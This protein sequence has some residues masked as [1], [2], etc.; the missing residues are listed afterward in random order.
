MLLHE[1][2]APYRLILASSSPRR[3]QLMAD[4]G[5]RFETAEKYECEETYPSDTAA[6]DVAAYLSVL[7]SRA[8]PKPLAANE[9]LVTADTTVVVGNE[10]LGKP[11]DRG[12]AVAMLRRLSGCG[13]IVITGVTVR[14]AVAERTFKASTTVRFRTLSDEEI[15]YYVDTFRPYDKAGAYGIQEWI[16]YAAVEGIEGSFYNVMGLPVQRLYMELDDFIGR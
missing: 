1:K 12:D 4:A 8:Y 5:L 13:H 2:L 14:S 6:E 10:V 9:I 7:K 11:A 3:R 16:G 15:A